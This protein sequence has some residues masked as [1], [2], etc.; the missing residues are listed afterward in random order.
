MPDVLFGSL[1]LQA[2][3]GVGRDIKGIDS[4]SSWP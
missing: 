2:G 1:G 4:Q 3:V